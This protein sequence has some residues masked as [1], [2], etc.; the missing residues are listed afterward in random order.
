MMWV[1]GY[2]YFLPYMFC[3]VEFNCTQVAVTLM[4]GDVQPGFLSN[5]LVTG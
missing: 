3:T 2:F 1:E 5:K 4:L